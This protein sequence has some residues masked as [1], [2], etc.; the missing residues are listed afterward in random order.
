MKKM[1]ILADTHTHSLASGHAYSTIQENVRAAAEKGLKLIA[2]TEHAPAMQNTT[3]HAYF[4]NLHVIPDE[5]F[6]V[7][8][9]K[10]VELNILDFEG[11]V[12]MDERTLSGLDLSIAS[13]HIPCIAPGTMKENTNACI[14]AME[15]SFVDIL[16]HPGDPRYPL[17]YDEIFN[18][19]KRTGTL[20]EIN[21][22]SLVP[23]GIRSGSDENIE[24]LLRRAMAE[25]VPIVV[26]S[27]AHF[28]TGIGD[29]YY[30][31]RLLEKIGFPEEL[32]LNTDPQKLLY[33][34]KRNKRQKK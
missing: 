15:N 3:S 34:I 14:R 13:L 24:K 22:A 19:A 7:R 17:D 11:S 20:L 21:N 2:L 30:V 25:D 16:G 6:G 18:V 27:D 4:A 1:K 9:L 10:G 32:V 8:V 31:E 28:Y 26:G 29:I 12:D 5:L 23:G 33:T